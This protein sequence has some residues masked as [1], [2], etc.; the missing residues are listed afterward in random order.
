MLKKFNKVIEILLPVFEMFSVLI[1]A[2]PNGLSQ[3][4]LPG[5]GG[6]QKQSV[7]LSSDDA[8]V[9][10]DHSENPLPAV[11]RDTIEKSSLVML[12]GEARILELRDLGI[13]F[14]LFGR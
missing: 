4:A 5:T 8:P 13:L 2:R 11:L 14:V 12:S 10:S 9:A 3:M 6:A 1:A 7:F